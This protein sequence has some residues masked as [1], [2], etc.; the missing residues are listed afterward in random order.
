MGK[1]KKRIGIVIG[2]ACLLLIVG[3]AWMARRTPPSTDD[4]R[5]MLERI[6]G[7]MGNDWSKVSE[8]EILPFTMIN[9]ED[10]TLIYYV[11]RTTYYTEEV[12]EVNGLSPALN[13]I[14]SPE[15]AEESRS[16]Q[17]CGLDA[18]LY[19]KDGRGYVCW[20]VSPQYSLAIE[21]TLENV[22]EEDIFRMAESIPS[23]TQN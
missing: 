13:E 3:S 18:M 4:P 19:E 11:C 17:V 22:P 20:T 23:N 14:I 8:T 6:E 7:A 12:P 5:E 2:A 21:Y 1:K 16:C 15:T 10:D 9:A